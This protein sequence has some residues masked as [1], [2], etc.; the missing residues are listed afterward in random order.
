MTAAEA[1]ESVR[2]GAGEPVA[3]HSVW[4]QGLG[5]NAASNQ[6][7][8][9]WLTANSVGHTLAVSQSPMTVEKAVYLPV[10]RA[11]TTTAAKK[12]IALRSAVRIGRD[13]DPPSRFRVRAQLSRVAGNPAER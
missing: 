13:M 9:A 7:A 3:P 10:I 1:G 11:M 4:V 5:N 2:R 8:T 6:L 12:K